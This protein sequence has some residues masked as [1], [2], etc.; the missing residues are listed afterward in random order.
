L[1]AGRWEKKRGI[2]RIFNNP[3]AGTAR[4]FN[5]GVFQGTSRFTVS[6]AVAFFRMDNEGF[7]THLNLSFD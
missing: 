1:L 6:A 5:A 3:Y 4:I 2:I 7:Y